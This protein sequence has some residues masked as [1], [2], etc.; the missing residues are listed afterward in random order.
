MNDID[1]DDRRH[2][3][4]RDLMQE[5]ARRSR[6]DFRTFTKVIAAGMTGRQNGAAPWHKLED[7]YS[8]LGWNTQDIELQRVA[9]K[10]DGWV[11]VTRGGKWYWVVSCSVPRWMR[12]QHLLPRCAACVAADDYRCVHLPLADLTPA[13]KL[14]VLALQGEDN[15]YVGATEHP[16]LRLE[17]HSS[18][19]GGS[20]FTGVNKPLRIVSCWMAPA[21]GFRE[22][23]DA[24]TLDL[25]RLHG[26]NHVAGGKY[27]GESGRR[28][29]LLALE[30]EEARASSPVILTFG[31]LAASLPAKAALPSLV[32]EVGKAGSRTA[33]TERGYPVGLRASSQTLISG[34]AA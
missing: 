3:A 5:I 4:S 6:R 32:N 16:L 1:I 10:R 24:A 11:R 14:Y 30:A 2:G 28:R 26:V 29:A 15:Y 34:G 13:M 22:A 23:E 31:D 20:L 9:L 8:R 17:Q 21:I 33:V 18:S 12:S 25:I 27:V 19:K 7:H